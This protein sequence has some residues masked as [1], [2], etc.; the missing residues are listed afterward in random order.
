MIDWKAVLHLAE[1]HI[2]Y[3]DR[4]VYGICRIGTAGIDDE[5]QLR[6]EAKI[7]GLEFEKVGHNL[8]AKKELQNAIR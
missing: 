6:I 4:G 5:R 8:Y 2:C 1:N 7:R 3:T